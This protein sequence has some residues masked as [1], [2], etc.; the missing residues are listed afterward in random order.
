M[1]FEFR[2]SFKQLVCRAEMQYA[3][4]CHWQVK[5][6]FRYGKSTKPLMKR[7]R[8]EAKHISLNW[9]FLQVFVLPTKFLT[10]F[11]GEKS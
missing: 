2:V 4:R 9:S 3:S 5:E 10:Q 7:G 11:N 1:R 8:T 6:S